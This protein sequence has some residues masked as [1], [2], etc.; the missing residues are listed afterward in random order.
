MVTGCVV[1]ICGSLH[2]DDFMRLVKLAAETPI[3]ADEA[4]T[5]DPSDKGY[6]IYVRQPGVQNAHDGG[7]KFYTQHLI[8]NLTAE[9]SRP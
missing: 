7:I 2:P 1:P 9:A 8:G 6:K 3:D 4:V 5:V